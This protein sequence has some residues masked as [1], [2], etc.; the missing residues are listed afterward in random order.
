MGVSLSK[1]LTY[2]MILNDFFP[3]GHSWY[4]CRTFVVT[5]LI[6]FLGQTIS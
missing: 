2:I 5:T 3:V 4:K 1:E 6:E